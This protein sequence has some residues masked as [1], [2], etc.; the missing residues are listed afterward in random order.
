MKK[1]YSQSPLWQLSYRVFLF[2]ALI[3]ILDFLAGAGLEWMFNNQKKGLFYRTS[4]GLERSTADLLIFGSSSASHHYVPKIIS[5]GLHMSVY[6]QGRDSMETLYAAAIL[7]GV[8]KRYSP[9]VIILNLTPSEL[10][11][12][13]NYDKLSIL[14]PYYKLHPEMR[15]IIRLRSKYESLKLLIKTYPYNSTILS[16]LSGLIGKSA[17]PSQGGYV[18]LYNTMDISRKKLITFK[19][20][21]ILDSNRVKAFESFVLSC[22]KKGIALFVVFSPWFYAKTDTTATITAA[23]RFCNLFDIPVYNHIL[24]PDF[25]GQNDLFADEGHLNHRGA[26]KFSVII[27]EKIGNFLKMTNARSLGNEVQ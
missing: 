7:N 15:A 13:D 17:R 6:N 26:S 2:V 3:Y 10:S 12:V 19:E 21:P 14:L 24:D 4:Y 20:E 11:T 22:K 27:T 18:S 25:L 8:L 1:D 23:T 16:L 9:R 5:D